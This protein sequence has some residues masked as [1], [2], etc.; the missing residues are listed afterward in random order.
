MIENMIDRKELG[1]EDV[2]QRAYEL[3]VRRGS[4]PGRD[5]EDWF[6]AEKELSGEVVAGPAKSMAAQAGRS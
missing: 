3:F 4:Q 1:R 2:A 5:I 6:R